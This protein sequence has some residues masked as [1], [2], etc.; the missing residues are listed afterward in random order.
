MEDFVFSLVVLGFS[1]FDFLDKIDADEDVEVD[2]FE[3]VGTLDP[4]LADRVDRRDET[5]EDRFRLMRSLLERPL[6]PRVIDTLF[7]SPSRRVLDLALDEEGL[8]LG[9]E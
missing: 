3:S 2:I 9:V 1:V 5:E 4:V 7:P 6:L 8:I